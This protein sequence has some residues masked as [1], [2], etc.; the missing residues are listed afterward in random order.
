MGLQ[1]GKKYGDFFE[2]SLF[3]EYHRIIAKRCTRPLVPLDLR[4]VANAFYAYAIN[5]SFK[6][7]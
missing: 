4:V 2:F 5:I 6:F 1:N 3:K 7:N